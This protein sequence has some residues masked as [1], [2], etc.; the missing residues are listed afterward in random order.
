MNFLILIYFIAQK[1]KFHRRLINLAPPI[2]KMSPLP[3]FS[4]ETLTWLRDNLYG[5]RRVVFTDDLNKAIENGLRGVDTRIDIC[6]N[7]KFQTFAGKIRQEVL[8]VIDSDVA[9]RIML[10]NHYQR[11]Q[12]SLDNYENDL[13]RKSDDYVVDTEVKMKISRSQIIQ[14]LLDISSSGPLVKGIEERV[15]ERTSLGPSFY[16]SVFMLGLTG[17]IIGSMIGSRLC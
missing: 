8:N 1:R 2:S 7:A 11:I 12:L 9:F 10:N 15:I 3:H 17:G 6:V 5:T 4:P 14:S 16:A 13:K